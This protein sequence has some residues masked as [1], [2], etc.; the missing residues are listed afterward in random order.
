MLSAVL[1]FKKTIGRR[2][3]GKGWG[4]SWGRDHGSDAVVMGGKSDRV[5][6]QLWGGGEGQVLIPT[7]AITQLWLIKVCTCL[8]TVFSFLKRLIC[9]S[10]QR[11]K[12]SRDQITWPT[13]VNYSSVPKTNVEEWTSWDEDAPTGVKTEGGNG[14]VATQ[15]NALEQVEPTLKMWHHL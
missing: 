10:G 15:Q 4:V 13:T 11:R 2:W 8:A 3:S 14:N 5:H 6:A 9:R 12:L 1:M 7:M